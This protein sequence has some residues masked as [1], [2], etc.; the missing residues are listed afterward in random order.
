[1]NTLKYFEILPG[2][3]SNFASSRTDESVFQTAQW[4]HFPVLMT[5]IFNNE[6]FQLWAA[7]DTESRGALTQPF[8][9]GLDEL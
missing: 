2:T 4:L 7:E 5:A 1:M 3:C 8:L 6:E 9:P